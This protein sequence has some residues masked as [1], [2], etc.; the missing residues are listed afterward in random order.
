MVFCG[1]AGGPFHGCVVQD[2]VL[3][4]VK[5]HVSLCRRFEVPGQRHGVWFPVVFGGSG[6][7]EA[8]RTTIHACI[9][10]GVIANMTVW[11][12]ASVR[13]PV[14]SGGFSWF[15]RPWCSPRRGSGVLFRMC[16]IEICGS[17]S[18]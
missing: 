4:G 10:H 11:D 16:E 17:N 18:K 15:R 9:F 3:A 7:W 5:S 1:F 6:L 14:V 13:A 12:A 2:C 8:R